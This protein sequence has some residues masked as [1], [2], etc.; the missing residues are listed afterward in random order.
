[1]VALGGQPDQAGW[2]RGSLFLAALGENS[3]SRSR[4]IKPGFFENEILVTLPF[5]QRL[6]FV[7]LWTIADREGRFEDRPTKLKMK[8]FPADNVDVEA[9]MSAL[10][11][12]GFISRYDHEDRRFCQILAWNKHQNP[13]FREKESTIPSQESLRLLCH[14]ST[15]SPEQASV[16]P[17]SSP[18]QARLIPD[19]LIPDSFLSTANAVLVTAGAGDVMNLEEFEK[20]KIEKCPVGKIVDLYHQS[21]PKHP[22]LLKLTKARAGAIR[23]RWSE[24]LPT[25][26][27]WSN[28]FTDVSNSPFLTGK[29]DPKDGHN[30]FIATLEWLCTAKNFAKVMEGKYHQ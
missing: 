12:H 20:P 7:G 15:K 16:K 30:R 18:E 29:V 11:A 6:F 25:L 23:A 21:L 13:H 28:Y 3:L 9:A 14:T 10:H 1:M 5:E 4:N 22:A 26:A 17:K 27:A 8:L 2:R 19:S 24:D